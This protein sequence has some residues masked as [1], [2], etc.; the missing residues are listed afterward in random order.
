MRDWDL[1]VVM[2]ELK[3]AQILRRTER[4]R[5]R[6]AELEEKKRTFWHRVMQAW[7]PTPKDLRAIRA[8][9]PAGAVTASE[10]GRELGIQ[11][12][13]IQEWA[14]KGVIPSV[15]H[16]QQRRFLVDDV[17]ARLALVVIGGRAYNRKGS[18]RQQ[19]LALRAEER[20]TNSSH[21]VCGRCRQSFP[22][23]SYPPSSGKRGHGFMCSD[24]ASPYKR[25]T[26]ARR[27][28]SIELT[29]VE[30]ISTMRVAKRDNW[31]CWLCSG[32]VT[33]ET[34]SLDH[35]IPLSKGGAHTYD[36]IK[37][38]H[39]DCNSRKNAKLPH[40]LTRVG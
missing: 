21:R 15:P 9:A 13:R 3:T 6:V 32:A 16:G 36:N 23:S 35:V 25:A 11:E 27:R 29:Q 38:A 37:L 28:S 33:R 18:E 30:H 20:A 4:K 39:R 5:R 31:T 34:W 12:R 19:Q 2:M 24:C 22:L 17:K 1:A 26:D 14:K 7:K 8:V 10:L 40:E